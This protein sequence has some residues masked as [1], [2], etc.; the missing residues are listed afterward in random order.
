MPGTCAMPAKHLGGVGQLRY[1]AWADEAG[2]FDRAQPGGRELIDQRD[3]VGS[4]DRLRFVLQAI[5]WANFD[6][7]DEV[8]HALTSLCA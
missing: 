2:R 4:G 5:A 6:N 7:A 1:P 8:A 3:L